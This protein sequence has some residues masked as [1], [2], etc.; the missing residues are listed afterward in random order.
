MRTIFDNIAANWSMI[1]IP[2]AVFAVSMI[3]LFWVRKVLL[4]YLAVKTKGAKWAEEISLLSSIK[5]PLAICCLIIGIY[6]G[7]AV[8]SIPS[9]WKHYIGNA[10][11]TLF[12]LALTI[13][14][15]N[16]SRNLINYLGDRQKLPI[17]II[18]ISRNIA[19]VVILVIA[20]LV[21]LELWGIPV[22]ALLLLIAVL[23][24]VAL[25][26]FR[27][28][29]P[30][31]LASFQIAATQE[32]KV[33]DYIKVDDNQEGYVAE[34]SW[35]TTHLKGLEGSIILIPNNILI[36]RKIVNYGRPLKKASEPFRFNTHVHL[37]ELTGFKARNLNEL[38]ETLKN[39]PDSV[40]Y[41]HTHHALE[42]D[43]YF[44]PELSNDFSN[45]IRNALDYDVLAEKLANVSIYESGSLLNFRNKIVEIIQEYIS[46]NSSQ[47]EAPEGRDFY[48]LKSVSV[49]F[50][51]AYAAHDLR[52]FIEALRKISPGSLYFHMFE[53]RLRLG[54]QLNDF[55]VWLE[56]SLDEA[57]LGQ[58]IAKIDPHTYTLEGLRSLLIRTIEKH[59]K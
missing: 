20:V 27:D 42:E 37:A 39:M 53:S 54:S 35:N 45:W 23:I 9:I 11:W 22:S 57:D 33:G 14:V 19:R 29:V 40:I 55:S 50:P 8:S 25:L 16:I 15:L 21:A 12:I 6:L 41:F 52:E 43:Q 32:I 26:A 28:S 18:L 10:L 48:F 46:H 56:K 49:V 1:A 4:D 38:F 5:G 44:H 17:R 7:F 36:R 34:I 58:E 31:L 51:T 3:A 2:V 30:N 59:I 47:R 24:L 13:T